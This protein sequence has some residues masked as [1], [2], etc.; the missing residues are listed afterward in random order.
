MYR[1]KQFPE[2]FKVVEQTVLQPHDQGNYVYVWMT[3]RLY[4]TVRACAAVA[5]YFGVQRKDVSFAGSKDH[6]A[7][8]RQLISV[9][10]P[11]QRITR[12]RV[13]SFR[14]RDLSLEWFGRGKD[15]VS[16]GDLLGNDFEIVVRDVP[17]Q[18]LVASQQWVMNYFDEQRFSAQNHVI[19]KLIIKGDF[20]KASSLIS[21]DYVRA[22]LAKSPADAVGA[23]K[24]LGIKEQL[25]YVHA[26]QS[27][28]WNET[29]RR[30]IRMMYGQSRMLV[31]Q[32]SVGELLFLKDLLEKDN[33]VVPLVGFATEYPDATIKG[34]VHAI[35]RE[36]GV[37]ERDFVIRSLP[38]LSSE[39]GMRSLLAEVKNFNAE[40]IDETTW[41]L[42][43]FL[44]KGAYATMLIRQLF[45]YLRTRSASL[46]MN[47]T[48]GVASM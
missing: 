48:V 29:V 12:D 45:S 2:D 24:C 44:P 35:M 6:D 19:G 30:Y 46:R 18:K 38:D 1:I 10:D 37:K 39:G 26:Y 23:I 41:K 40:K 15:P 36:E 14:Q 22:H 8:T 16:L 21:D 7:V 28:L 3:K 20:V 43:F 13:A 25:L 47:S 17:A 42:S 4:N 31:V 32:T 5:D 34:I 11:Q 27:W 9:R 33:V